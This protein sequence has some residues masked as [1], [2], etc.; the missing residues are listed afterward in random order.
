MIIYTNIHDLMLENLEHT[1]Y[2]HLIPQ[3]SK[4]TT[5]LML[6]GKLD[7]W[8]SIK[9]IKGGL[10]LDISNNT[11]EMKISIIYVA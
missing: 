1:K 7:A 3:L 2:D 5:S 9:F 11:S 6:K 10:K 8:L 4:I